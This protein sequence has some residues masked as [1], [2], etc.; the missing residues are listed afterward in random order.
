MKF[1]ISIVFLLLVCLSADA[2]PGVALRIKR[3]GAPEAA[4]T[5]DAMAFMMDK[6]SR[7]IHEYRLDNIIPVQSG[8]D[9]KFNWYRGGWQNP[10]YLA[11][12]SG[13]LNVPSDG[14]YTFEIHTSSPVYF[15]LNDKLILQQSDFRFRDPRKNPETPKISG[16]TIKLKTGPAKIRIITMCRDRLNLALLWKTPK[17]PSTFI[18]IAAADWLEAPVFSADRKTARYSF[19]TINGAFSPVLDASGEIK[20]AEYSPDAKPLIEYRLAADIYGISAICDTN[21]KISMEIQGNTDAPAF[22]PIDFEASVVTVSNNITETND[23]KSAIAFNKGWGRLELPVYSVRELRSVQWKASHR[24]IAVVS[25]T[26]VFLQRPYDTVPDEI[27]NEALY[28]N[29]IRIVP[30]TSRNGISK[31]LLKID[32]KAQD[33]SVL[34]GFITSFAN[35]SSEIGK[36][37]D[38]TF[39]N[40]MPAVVYRRISPISHTKPDQVPFSSRNLQS[41]LSIGEIKNSSTV[42]IAPEIR[43]AYYGESLADFEKKLLAE[44]AFLR[45]PG[46]CEIILITPP[47]GIIDESEPNSVRDYAAVIHLVADL[48]GAKVIDLYTLGKTKNI[49]CADTVRHCL[50][51]AGVQLTVKSLHAILPPR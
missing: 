12:I 10:I 29:G 45:D 18:P 9:S 48:E 43:G 17:S 25:G 30:V 36:N 41:L 49:Q 39:T 37:F 3:A 13:N 34:D 5:P 15:W 6:P 27:R 24:G 4:P 26:V 21:E 19:S 46:K 50:S 1:F 2:A 35:G 22:V 38:Q 23:F 14:N 31:A 40:A 11:E 42:I 32:S 20:R 7:R 8:R 44:I 16:E 51:E 28:S 47:E 33:V